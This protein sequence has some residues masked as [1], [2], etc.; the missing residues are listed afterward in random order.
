MRLAARFLTVLVA[1]VLALYPT[2]LYPG[3]ESVLIIGAAGLAAIVV[4]VL[5]SSWWAMV[6]GL[7]MIVVGYATVLI[8]ERGT[9]EI[10]A[11]LFGIALVLLIETFDISISASRE[12]SIER[13]AVVAR[14][15]DLLH[16]VPIALAGG[17]IVLF[18]GVYGG[19]GGVLVA[20]VGALC[21]ATAFGVL[22][23][24]ARPEG[25]QWS[26]RSRTGGKDPE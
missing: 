7:V 16:S 9:I 11:P 10:T 18:A 2:I 6:P 19:D 24:V 23:R 21:V 17:V 4:A 3:H 1:G 12:R 22:T 26:G 14:L 5:L 20:G 13:L 25:I 8:L 15:R